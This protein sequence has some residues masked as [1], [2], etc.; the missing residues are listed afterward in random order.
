LVEIVFALEDQFGLE[1]SETDA[2]KVGTVGDL[3]ALIE[4]EPSA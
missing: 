4:P 3:I 2:E 1:I